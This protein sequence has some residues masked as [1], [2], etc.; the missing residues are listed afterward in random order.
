[1]CKTLTAV[2]ITLVFAM[3]ASAQNGCGVKA[4]FTPG[5][6]TTLYTGQAITFTRE[7]F[8]EFLQADLDALPEIEPRNKI[9]HKQIIA[10]IKAKPDYKYSDEGQYATREELLELIPDLDMEVI[11][12]ALIDMIEIYDLKFVGSTEILHFPSHY[13]K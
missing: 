7:N 4:S 5:N 2:M 10:A 11:T 3:K 8:C 13:F 12:S 6:D 9:I 1:M